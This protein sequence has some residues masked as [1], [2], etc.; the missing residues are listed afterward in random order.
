[1]SYQNAKEILNDSFQYIK[2]S[3]DPVSHNLAAGL[4]QLSE[5]LEAI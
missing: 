1:M 2:A 4:Y 5:A 3:E